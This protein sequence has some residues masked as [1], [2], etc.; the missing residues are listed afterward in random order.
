MPRQNYIFLCSGIENV[1]GKEFQ[2]SL[3]GASSAARCCRLA[4]LAA[5][6]RATFCFLASKRATFKHILHFNFE[7]DNLTY[8]LSFL[9]LFSLNLRFPFLLF[10]LSLCFLHG[11]IRE[12]TFL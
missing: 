2:D 10:F 11:S 6:A 3:A 9:L 12:S 7:I 4:F 1:T 8:F 5:F